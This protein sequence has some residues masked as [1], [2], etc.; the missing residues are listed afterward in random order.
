MENELVLFREMKFTGG[1]NITELYL[2]TDM[3]YLQTN[4]FIAG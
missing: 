4:V 3:S 1:E 2:E